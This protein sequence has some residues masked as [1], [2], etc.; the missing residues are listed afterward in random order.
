M[1]KYSDAMGQVSHKRDVEG[2]NNNKRKF[3]GMVF[4]QEEVSVNHAH[5]LLHCAN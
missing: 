4:T 2:R 1:K 3:N 5:A